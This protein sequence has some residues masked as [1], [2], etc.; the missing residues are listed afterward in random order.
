MTQAT[1]IKAPRTSEQE[2]AELLLKHIEEADAILIG[3][4]AGM[5]TAAGHRFYYER[6][7]KFVEVFGKFEEKYGFHNSFNGFYYPYPT[8][9][10]HW[11]FLITA[12]K[13]IRDSYEGQPY[14]D[15]AALMEGKN[16]HVLTT[17]QDTLMERVFP[18]E[19]VSAI[20]GDWRYFQC[21]KRCH[22]QVYRNDDMIDELYDAIEGTALPSE[23]IPHCPKCGA[24][25]EPWIRG[26]TFLEGT[27]YAEE[28]GKVNRFLEDNKD[29]KILFLELGVGRM[30][31]MFIQEPFWNLT[32]TLPK[33]YYISI[34]PKDACMPQ[35]LEGKGTLIPKDIAA[36]LADA[37][38]LKKQETER[39][40]GRHDNE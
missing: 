11:G 9:E 31:P 34:N 27:K 21:S 18:P 20:Q 2:Y 12:I 16:F 1:A 10:E 23:L 30:T 5:S 39:T 33:A 19:K 36:V 22:D 28:Y 4:A 7:D 29:K 40:E 26:Y 13:N 14:H 6:D 35:Q 17:N 32:Y 24:E 37:A 8:P 15:L 38:A 3:A 25:M